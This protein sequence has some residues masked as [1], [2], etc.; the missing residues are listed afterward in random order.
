MISDIKLIDSNKKN[1]FVLS[2]D[3]GSSLSYLSWKSHF[4]KSI[5]I[6]LDYKGHGLRSDK[7]LDSNIFDMADDIAEQIVAISSKKRF[8]IF[9]HSMG[10][11]VGW[12]TMHIL[13]NRYNILPEILCI[14]ACKSPDS[15][16]TKRQMITNETLLSNYSLIGHAN[17]HMVKSDYFKEKLLPVI[18]HDYQLMNNFIYEERLEKISIPFYLF[19]GTMDTSIVYDEIQS[20][21]SFTTS[22]YRSFSFDGGHFY[23]DD[24]KN[25]NKLCNIL[26]HL[27]D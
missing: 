21:C 25:R 20:W 13:K 15:F 14:S 2:Y 8:I 18:K 5:M 23:F 4:E 26:D 6:P 19:Y 12:Y 16:K 10:G 1:I 11:L 7:K 17:E 22:Y 9:G 27:C 3:G 24:N